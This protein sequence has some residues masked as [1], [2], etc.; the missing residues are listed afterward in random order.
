MVMRGVKCALVVTDMPFM[1]YQISPQQAL[2][3]AGRLV[4]EGV[5]RRSSSKAAFACAAVAAITAVD[6]AL[7]GHIGLTPQ[8]VRRLGGFKVQRERRQVWLM[9]LWP[10]SGRRVCAGG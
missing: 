10:S 4:K 9:T 7:M 6:I 5:R 3:N 2:E 1:S 8:S